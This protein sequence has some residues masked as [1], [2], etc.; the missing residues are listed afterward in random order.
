M[1]QI[2]S[3]PC[4]RFQGGIFWYTEPTWSE[5]P[6]SSVNMSVVQALNMLLCT[7]SSLFS[8]LIGFW[9]GCRLPRMVIV[10]DIPQCS[11]NES[12]SFCKDNGH[13]LLAI[14]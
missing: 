7:S 6:T 5:V 4:S 1:E 12:Q 10:N 8:F 2:L 9:I 11:L 13:P 14:S 3:I